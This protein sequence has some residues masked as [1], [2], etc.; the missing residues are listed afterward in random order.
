[1]K[2]ILVLNNYSINR[3]LK[4]YEEGKKPSH[5]LYGIIELKKM[6]HSIIVI[7]PNNHSFLYKFS[8][9][10]RGMPL[11]YIG[12]LQQQFEAIFNYKKYDLVYAPCQDTTIFL[13]VLSY[14]KLFRKPIIA[15]AHHPML[16][17]H[18]AKFRKYSLF[19][20]I[21]GHYRFLSLSKIVETQLNYIA[22]K[23]I[24]QEVFWGPELNYY[25]KVN[26][27][28]KK[29]IKIYDI[30]SVGR[31]GR[32]YQ[33]LIK[34][35][36]NTSVNVCIYCSESLKNLLPVVVTKNITIKWLQ[37]QEALDYIDLIHLYLSAKIL[38]IP[39]HDEDS[40]C[41]LTSLTDSIALGMPTIIT[42]NKYINIDPELNHFGIWVDAYDVNA[43]KDSAQKI[44]NDTNL[45]EAMSKN[46]KQTAST[47][48][49][50]NLFSKS[51]IKTIDNI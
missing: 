12:N 3:V 39:M 45:F 18:L 49:N 17:G 29:P 21:N 1:M 32:D 42:R 8:N 23:N 15:L 31:T 47:T 33:T 43:W 20:S 36:N 10:L 2:R 34:A 6:G 40:L 22:H 51:L 24:S 48:F 5:H 41:G 27:E 28:I 11:L 4:E 35:F 14:F 26:D 46:A 13:G 16:R 44:L 30:I 25:N 7:D 37:S 50:I 9:I 19:F 38:A